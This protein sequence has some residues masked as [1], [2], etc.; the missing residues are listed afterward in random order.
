MA[1]HKEVIAKGETMQN[2]SNIHGIAPNHERAALK[3]EI[4]K[5]KR[6]RKLVDNFNLFKKDREEYIIIKA[7]KLY[8]IIYNLKKRDARLYKSANI[9]ILK[10]ILTNLEEIKKKL[11]EKNNKLKI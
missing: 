11:I 10:K 5:Y 6:L 9:K 7:S 8:K 3:R 2:A 4:E 1:N